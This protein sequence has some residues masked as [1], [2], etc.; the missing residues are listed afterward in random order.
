M[1]PSIS[2]LLDRPADRT[3]MTRILNVIR[4]PVGGIRSYLR[5][6]YAALPPDE[7][8]TTVLTIDVEEAHLMGAGLGAGSRLEFVADRDATLRLGLSAMRELQSGQYGLVHSQGTTAG[9]V[10]APGARMLGVP[11]VVTLHETFRPEQFAGWRGAVTRSAVRLMID[12]ADAV[13]VLG[14][15]ALTNLVEH[16]QVDDRALRKV[17]I[18]RNGVPVRWLIEEGARQRPELRR[19]LA[20]PPD[21]ALLGFVGRFMP[22]KGFDLLVQAAHQL[23]QRGT[24]LPPF[25]I[26][27]VNDGAYMR[28]YRDLI[29]SLGIAPLFSFVGLQP[30]AAGTLLEL[31]AV[32]MPSR[33]EACGLVAMEALVL[34]CPLIA[35]NCF[36]LREVTAG[37]P[38]IE[39]AN[40]DAG[41]LALAIERFLTHRGDV[42]RQASAFVDRARD[43]FEAA[44][45]ARQMADLFRQAGAPAAS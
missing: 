43:A 5:Y 38:A 23:S 25:R 19:R 35:S 28:E 11:H 33:R 2:P 41:S 27:A 15:D 44:N 32:V 17:H 8:T 30:S 39:A 4:H 9:I 31:D 10:A 7:W 22:E 3:Y 45:T 42:A 12:L 34:G 20:L 13:V 36:G 37:T 24:A 21:V 29:A 26:V 14:D 1:Y 40:G 18:I 6:T 16:V